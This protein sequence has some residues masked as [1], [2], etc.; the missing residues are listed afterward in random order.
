MHDARMHACVSTGGHVARN[1]NACGSVSHYCNGACTWNTEKGKC[2]AS[3]VNDHHGAVIDLCKRMS[4]GL[5]AVA[6]MDPAQVHYL[7]YEDLAR[8]PMEVTRIVYDFLV[9]I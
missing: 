1:C 4:G 9:R 8:Q 5:Q 7:R 2:Q 3:F 6:S